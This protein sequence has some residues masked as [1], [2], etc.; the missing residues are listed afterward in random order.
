MLIVNYG[1]FFLLPTVVF[2]FVINDDSIL[3]NCCMLF[4]WE[5]SHIFVFELPLE[6]LF[7]V[8]LGLVSN[9][10]ITQLAVIIPPCEDSGRRCRTA[11][12]GAT[13]YITITRQITTSHQSNIVLRLCVGILK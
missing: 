8:C 12:V 4:C 2:A 10:I 13:K 6:L 11:G 3:Y 5:S 9:G 7:K 1:I